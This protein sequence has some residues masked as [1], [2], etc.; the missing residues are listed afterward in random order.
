VEVAIVGDRRMSE[1]REGEVR[2]VTDVGG[3]GDGS[4]H[5][6][7]PGVLEDLIFFLA[8]SAS[9]TKSRHIL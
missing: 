8:R 7:E 1:G 3:A 2:G 5:L 6:A 4:R 9:A